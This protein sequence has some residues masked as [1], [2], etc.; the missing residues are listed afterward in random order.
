MFLQQFQHSD[1][2][3]LYKPI[4]RDHRDVYQWKTLAIQ[5]LGHLWLREII[6]PARRV[7]V[8]AILP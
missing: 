4:V 7:R 2:A 8:G 5:P 3:V 1:T 6:Q